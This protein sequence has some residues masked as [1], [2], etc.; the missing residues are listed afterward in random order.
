MRNIAVGTPHLWLST[1]LVSTNVLAQVQL[2]DENAYNPIPS[3]DGSRIVAVRTGWHREGGS[4]GLGRSNLRSDLIVLDRTGRTL[5]PLLHADSFVADWNHSGIVAFRDWSYALLSESGRVRY[6]GRVCPSELIGNPTSGCVERVA[7]LPGLDSFLWVHQK[8][9]DSALTT[10]RGEL[11]VHHH[12]KYLGEWLAPSPDGRY[13]AVGPARLGRSLNIYDLQQKTWSDFGAAVINPATEWEWMEP[14]WN[15]WFADS[16]RIA[17]FTAEGLTVGSLDGK[18]KRIVLHTEEPAGLAVP[19]PN[20]RAI[21]YATFASRP[22]PER[23]NLLRIWNCTGIWVVV[24]D[25]ASQPRRVVGQT[26]GL[27]YDLRWLDNEHLVFD[28]VEEGL[29]PRARLWTVAA[30]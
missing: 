21:A 30:N 8:F 13:I 9:G 19:S 6:E 15:P 17:F 20:G 29:P 25:G 11:S 28:R 23:G 7:Y 27:T 12:E 18:R 26:L 5:S 16:S 24:L 2:S 1:L 14:S 22:R 3:P 10:P 4:G